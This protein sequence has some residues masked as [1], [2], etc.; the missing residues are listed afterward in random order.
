MA[1]TIIDTNITVDY[2][3]LDGSP[4]EGYS[5]DGTFEASR[6]LQ[7]DWANRETLVRQ[8]LGDTIAT[9]SDVLVTR[10]HKYPG[11]SLAVAKGISGI[12]G[13]GRVMDAAGDL[14]VASYEKA[15][16]S[17]KYV[18]SK[19]ANDS[20]EGS[21]GEDPEIYSENLRPSA[22]YLTFPNRKSTELYP[23]D[24]S[25][26]DIIKQ[27]PVIP[28]ILPG[29]EWQITKK[30]RNSLSFSSAD[31]WGMLGKINSDA[32]VS[33]WY[34]TTFAVG[35]LL[36]MPFEVSREVLRSGQGLW[37]IGLKMIY[38]PQGWNSFYYLDKNSMPSS[39]PGPLRKNPGGALYEPY[40]SAAYGPIINA[41][42]GA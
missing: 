18:Q 22:E 24:G 4:Q 36:W 17:V 12:Q 25:S 1:T 5:D 10:A 30:K 33:N 21:A 9:D 26:A 42:R 31:L 40:T 6:T 35:T 23:A 27:N 2:E 13:V 39:G 8:L 7:C 38:K 14:T 11:N 15:R 20:N 34:A 28:I 29:A 16:L 32:V 3:E 19:N 37:T 41:L